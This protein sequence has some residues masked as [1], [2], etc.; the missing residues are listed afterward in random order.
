MESLPLKTHAIRERAVRIIVDG[1]P[2]TPNFSG[3]P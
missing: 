2:D 3:W 1:A